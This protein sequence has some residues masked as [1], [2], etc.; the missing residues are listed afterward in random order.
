MHDDTRQNPSNLPDLKS[1]VE[2][3]VEVFTQI[4]SSVGDLKEL[5]IQRATLEYYRD[6]VAAAGTDGLDPVS[7][8]IMLVNLRQ[9]KLS[10]GNYG[11][12]SFDT[13]KETITVEDFKEWLSNVADRIK[14]LID[15]L[16]KMAK[17]YASKI[18]SGIEGVK[19]ESEDLINRARG[20]KKGPQLRVGNELHGEGQIIKIE[21]PATLWANGELCLGD[22]KSEQDVIKFFSTV[23][24][25]YAKDQITRAKKMI[26]EYDVES[27][28]SENF[29]SNIG[30]LGNHQSLVA[31]ITKQVLPGN[32]SVAFEYVAL[33]PKLVEAENAEPAPSSYEV[34]VRTNTEIQSTLKS[35]I[36]TMN[37][38]SHMFKAESDVLHDMSSLSEALMDLENRRGETVWKSARDGLDDISKA[39]MDLI[40]R[41]KPNYDPIVRHLAKV[42]QARNAVCNLELSKLGQ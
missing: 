22:C 33:G 30:F 20:R 1:P 42:G 15:K 26:G 4:D 39:M 11:L 17:E 10:R 29:E 25:K 19:S 28:N 9:L 36:A 23:W 32:V 6:Q 24:P 18:M 21:S 16:I 5:I 37:A 8:Q 41:L 2:E 12:E 27:G 40:S 14:E 34:T 7:S 31:N 35:N 3:D 38:L 13:N